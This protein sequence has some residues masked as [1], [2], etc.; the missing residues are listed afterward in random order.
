MSEELPARL[1]RQSFNCGA[2]LTSTISLILLASPHAARAALAQSEPPSG[3]ASSEQVDEDSSADI[4][5]TANRRSENLQDVAASLTVLDGDTLND[6]GILN[7]L[8]LARSVPSL[9]VEP[10]VGIA[11][12]RLYIRGIGTA[13]FNANAANPV[14]TN[15]DDV[16]IGFINATAVQLF[17]VQRIEVLRGP[18]GTLYGR[19]TTGGAINY[20]S[21]G[22][23]ATLGG[24]VNARYGRFD[25]RQITAAVTGP[26]VGDTL[27]ARLAFNYEGRDGLGTNTV[28]GL[29]NLG[30][31]DN[32]ALRGLLR[33]RPDDT[34]DILLNVHGGSAR[35]Q[36][37]PWTVQGIIDPVTGGP[38]SP[39][40]VTALQCANALGY[41]RPAIG[42]YDAEYDY[43]GLRGQ[44]L[45]E[46]LD[47]IGTSL[48]ATYELGFAEVT[49]ITAYEYADYQR[50]EDTDATPL[51]I[52]HIDNDDRFSQFSQEL[53]LASP[54]GRRFNW[55]VGGFYYH[56]VTRHRSQS[57]V[58]RALRPVFGFSPANF[59]LFADQ[60]YR[61]TTDAY[62]VFGRIDYKIV[63]KL[64]VAFGLRYTNETRQLDQ[65]IN[66]VEPTFTIPLVAVDR[67]LR[68]DN[69][70]GEV[71]IEYTATDDLLLYAAVARGFK[72]GG[73]NGGLV[74]SNA[75][76]TSYRPET[77]TSYEV[78][79]KS[80]WSRALRLNA[81]GFYYDYK[82]LQLFTFVNQ[83]GIPTQ[84]L[85][86]AGSAELYGFEAELVYSPVRQLDLGAN[87]GYVHSRLTR[88]I[89]SFGP[90]LSG[91]QLAGAPEVT[92]NFSADYGFDVGDWGISLHADTAYRSRSFFTQ[93]NS[94]F[95]VKPSYWV[96][97]ARIA[98]TPPGE[99]FTIAAFGS[100][101][102]NSRYNNA[103]Q[104]LSS[105][106]EYFAV[107]ADPATWGVE[108]RV[109]F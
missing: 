6:R 42:R 32:W 52:L 38:C 27:T 10:V 103:V 31:R 102:F 5:V 60:N 68:N 49:S 26:V 76:V 88:Y 47:T 100:N 62:A 61:Q 105:F 58:L 33:F 30:S 106:G 15:V 66:L 67:R 69:V 50:A 25:A 97:G 98:V 104:D 70:S 81:S 44:G 92:L 22:P 14:T 2:L 95:L 85:D 86:N 107:P 34:L 48:K 89:T 12:P 74:F 71:K 39:A 93:S 29:R 90:D 54:S 28:T 77:L 108:L 75:A 20:L 55:I 17:D 7:T 41:V 36:Q 63:D 24:Y 18:Q 56:D 78:G 16:Y 53:R 37:V 109:R 96:T 1:K 21:N 35:A 59:V 9:T 57:D 19:N 65:T 94:P 4:V 3:G 46:R 64:S 99:Q 80:Q 8:D 72:S 45:G 84:V 83:G 73:F 79:V 91:N 13:D 43:R 40:A 11:A 51:A 23:S 82:D 87:I 101:I